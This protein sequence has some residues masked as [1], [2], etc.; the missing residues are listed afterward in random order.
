[1]DASFEEYIDILEQRK[2]LEAIGQEKI[3]VALSALKEFIIDHRICKPDAV[4]E[5][6]ENRVT[7]KTTELYTTQRLL[8]IEEFTG[9]TLVYKD[10]GSLIFQYGD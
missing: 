1:M 4:I 3:E 5:I 8:E 2:Q 9:F 10:Q 7:I 6:T